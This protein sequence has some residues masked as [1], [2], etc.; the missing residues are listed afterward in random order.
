MDK[1]IDINY[2]GNTEEMYGYII[3]TVKK[4]SYEVLGR[5]S[6]KIKRNGWINKDIL[7]E[8]DEKIYTYQKWLSS[9]KEEDKKV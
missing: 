2:D 6:R 7:K 3:N 9:S 1:E 4:I 5:E 8:I